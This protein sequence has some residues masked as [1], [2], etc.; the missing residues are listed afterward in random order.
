MALQVFGSFT[1]A[2]LSAPETTSPPVS[3]AA[4]SSE[5]IVKL[6]RENW[7]PTGALLELYVSFDSQATWQL[8]ASAQ[9]APFVVTPKQVTPTPA[10]IGWGWEREVFGQ[11][12]H[13]RGRIVTPLNF[14]ADI[15]LLR[16]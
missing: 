3:I 1:N 13:A 6:S 10:T 9:V 11:P 8:K 14:R 2:L 15:T 5:V 16:E 12:T 7:P 4:D